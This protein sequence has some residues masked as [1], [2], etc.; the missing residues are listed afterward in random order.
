MTREKLIT[1][2]PN[3]S[4]FY[5]DGNDV[6]YRELSKLK[7]SKIVDIGFHPSYREGGLTIDFKKDDSEEINRIVIGSN[8][9]GCW[10]VEDLSN[11]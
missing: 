6:L 4:S 11:L 9:L 2:N 5:K 7:G 10:V 1:E 3:K 8:D